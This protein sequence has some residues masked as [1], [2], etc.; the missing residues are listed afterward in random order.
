M[1][2]RITNPAT[3]LP[4]ATESVQGLYKAINSGGV[5]QRTLDLVHLRAIQING[6]SACVHAG[7]RSAVGS[8]G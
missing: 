3:L 6:C 1:Q 4:N 8:W 7:T 5:P 2:A